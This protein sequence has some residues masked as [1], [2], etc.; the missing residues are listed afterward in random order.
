MAKQL[1]VIEISKILTESD[2]DTT[3][4]VGVDSIID[5][6]ICIYNRSVIIRFSGKRA[7]TIFTEDIEEPYIDEIHRELKEI[8]LLLDLYTVLYKDIGDRG[9]VLS[10]DIHEKWFNRFKFQGRTKRLKIEGCYDH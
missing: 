7:C 3:V 8:M 5:G 1:D 2:S 4:A 9:I 6:N 10:T